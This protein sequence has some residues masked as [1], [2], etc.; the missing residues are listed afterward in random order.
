MKKILL[1]AILLSGIVTNAQQIIVD[2]KY[3][4]D[5]IPLE[6]DYL[7]K[8]D[9]III[10][11]GKLVGGST[12]KKTNNIYAYDKT[13]KKEVLLQNDE[14]MN[15]FYSVTEK[16]FRVTNYQSMSYNGKEYKI[17]TNGK[18]SP[19]LNEDDM[20]IMFNDNFEIK[21]LN[22]KNEMNEINL[23]KD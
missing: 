13:G 22:Q 16:S 21:V 9:K 11:K 15:S 4:K 2:E 23:A 1:T 8:Q 10:E 7:L 12:N 14:V 6:Y 19:I 18:T 5:N 17:H 20:A 3:E